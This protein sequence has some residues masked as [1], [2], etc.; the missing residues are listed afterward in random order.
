MLDIIQVPGR[1]EFIR[2][3]LPAFV[4]TIEKQILAYPE[5]WEQWMSI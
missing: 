3:N 5:Q 1:D 2:A 4:D